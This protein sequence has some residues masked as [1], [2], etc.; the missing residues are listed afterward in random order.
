[1]ILGTKMCTVIA[2]ALLLLL[3]GQ[4][5]PLTTDIVKENYGEKLASL[6]TRQKG[7]H[8][9]EIPVARRNYRG[10]NIRH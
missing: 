8:F 9:K 7:T 3:P 5:L 10:K 2:A 1:M 4:A 6:A